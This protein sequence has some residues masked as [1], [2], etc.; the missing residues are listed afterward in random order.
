MEM[1]PWKSHGILSRV[2][3]IRHPSTLAALVVVAHKEEEDL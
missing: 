1:R 3:V 2:R